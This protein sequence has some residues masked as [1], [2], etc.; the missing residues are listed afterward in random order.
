MP[1]IIS[2]RSIISARAHQTSDPL[3]C[4][5]QPTSQSPPV[6][7]HPLFFA[8]PRLGPLDVDIDAVPRFASEL[9]SCKLLC[10]VALFL[11][12]LVLKLR[13]TGMIVLRTQKLQQ[14]ESLLHLIGERDARRVR[15]ILEA[16]VDSLMAW[17]RGQLGEVIVSCAAG[18][19]G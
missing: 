17:S 13:L 16:A 1:S 15:P 14:L 18:R 6:L 5:L 10:L 8:L 9:A 3:P 19:V 11:L 2:R 12:A 4:H 7:L